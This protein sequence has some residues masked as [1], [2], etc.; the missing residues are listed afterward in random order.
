MTTIAKTYKL[1]EYKLDLDKCLTEAD[2]PSTSKFFTKKI[3]CA[4]RK[5]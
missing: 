1:C 5:I 4:F 2:G 3:L